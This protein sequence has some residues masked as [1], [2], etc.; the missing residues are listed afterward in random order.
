[1]Y[2]KTYPWKT[3]QSNTPW[4]HK[5]EWKTVEWWW[6]EGWKCWEKNWQQVATGQ[7][8]SMTE[9]WNQ[10]FLEII[11]FTDSPIIKRNFSDEP[12]IFLRMFSM[13]LIFDKKERGIFFNKPSENWKIVNFGSNVFQNV[14]C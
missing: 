5:V 8:E 4:S 11:G 1:M 13:K 6:R 3:F 14:T 2:I 7:N 10:I 12:S 9:L